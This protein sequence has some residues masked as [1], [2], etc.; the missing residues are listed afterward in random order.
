MVGIA[1]S[2]TG[3]DIWKC[4]FA[5]ALKVRGGTEILFEKTIEHRRLVTCC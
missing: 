2:G 4:G 3:G 1:V 5:L